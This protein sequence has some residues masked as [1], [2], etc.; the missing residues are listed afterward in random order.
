[1]YIYIYIYIYIYMYCYYYIID[2]LPKSK[3]A[4]AQC[5]IL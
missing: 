5:L 3:T 2:E 4:A 1:M